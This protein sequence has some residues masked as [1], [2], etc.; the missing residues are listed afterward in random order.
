MTITA[1]KSSSPATQ[2]KGWNYSKKSIEKTLDAYVYARNPL[3]MEE[4]R[5]DAYRLIYR[6]YTLDASGKVMGK[7]KLVNEFLDKAAKD[8]NP[9][10]RLRASIL[11]V[12]AIICGTPGLKEKMQVRFEFFEDHVMPLH[13]AAAELLKKVVEAKTQKD[14]RIRLQQIVQKLPITGEQGTRPA[15]APK[16]P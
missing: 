11:K 5:E 9:D 14:E 4:K 6:L 3:L 15:E 7:R 12:A 8:E 10:A 16:K 13:T 2:F 1:N